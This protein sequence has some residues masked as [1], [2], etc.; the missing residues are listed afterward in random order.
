VGVHVVF[1]PVLDV[2]SN[3]ENPIINTRAFGEDPGAVGVLGRAF[4]RGIRSR[5]RPRWGSTSRGTAT[6]GWTRT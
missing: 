3:P 2:N 5:G 1:A 4:V 6:P